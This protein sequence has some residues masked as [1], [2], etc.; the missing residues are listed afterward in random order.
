MRSSE[1][2]AA[3][4][5]GGGTTGRTRE[6]RW[7]GASASRRAAVAQQVWAVTLPLRERSP[8]PQFPCLEQLCLP[9]TVSGRFYILRASRFKFYSP[10]ALC[11]PPSERRFRPVGCRRRPQC[12]LR[13]P[14]RWPGLRPALLRPGVCAPRQGRQGARAPLLERVR[15]PRPL[16]LA[17]L[18]ATRAPAAEATAVTPV[19]SALGGADAVPRSQRKQ[20][21]AAAAARVAER[22]EKTPRGAAEEKHEH[23]QRSGVIALLAV[24]PGGCRDG[25]AAAAAT[26]AARRRGQKLSSPISRCC[27]M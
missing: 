6:A 23:T 5:A 7:R 10:R 26:R 4:A 27:Q 14:R 1:V 22:T 9:A 18:T 17:A 15:H 12:L 16:L 13:L 3:D 21:S 8:T 25:G 19:T 11:Q 24:I 2:A 20:R